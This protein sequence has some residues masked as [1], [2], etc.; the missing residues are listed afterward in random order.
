MDSKDNNFRLVITLT[1]SVIAIAAYNSLFY[2]GYLTPDSA[3]ILY[4]TNGIAPLSNWHPI[5]IT[6]LW[7]VLYDIFKS[8]G[9]IWSIQI[10]LLVL[11]ATFMSLKIKNATIGI[12]FLVLTLFYPP[13]MTNMGA[14]WKDDF[15]AIFTLISYAFLIS[16]FNKTTRY[17]LS[18]LISSCIIVSLTRI[19]YFIVI[20]PFILAATIPMGYLNI[21]NALSRFS[22]YVLIVLLSV[23]II[24]KLLSVGIEKKLNPWVTIA[25]WDIVGI[26]QRSGEKDLSSIYNCSTSDPLVWGDTKRFSVNLPEGDYVT[27]VKEESSYFFKLWFNSIIKH[28]A[29][30]FE[31]RM[32]VAKTF[33]GF[34]TPSVHYPY[35][36]PIF[37]NYNLS[38]KSDRSNLNLD[39][40]WFFDAS[41]S[42]PMFRYWYYLV[43]VIFIT[44]AMNA[45]RKFS[46]VN[47]ALSASILLE[48][49]RVLVLPAADFRYGIWIVFGTITLIFVSIDKI[50]N[51]R[52]DL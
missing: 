20:L 24:N 41:S 2:P 18:L 44:L 31:H 25:A 12:S 52:D 33:F 6:R 35:P 28:P 21:K 26:E 22:Y 4:Q 37:N 19:D 49:L 38:Q 27:P 11:S 1:V 47:N 5:F 43:V 51:K 7:G 34:N 29:S 16:Y 30:Y 45:M 23:F 13:I 46:I 48:A 32:C 36:S 40:Y 9:G 42:S 17:N 3:Y 8:A 10:L 14:L 39:A 50:F 15:A